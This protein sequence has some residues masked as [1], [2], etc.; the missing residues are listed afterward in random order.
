LEE[1]LEEE[2]GPGTAGGKRR[3]LGVTASTI[4]GC[5]FAVD[6]LEGAQR[7]RQLA[8]QPVLEYC[9]YIPKTRRF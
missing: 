4:Y 9:Y 2:E 6:Q 7:R 1:P 8:S 5:A 3:R